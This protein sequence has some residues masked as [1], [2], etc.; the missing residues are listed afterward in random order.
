MRHNFRELEIWKESKKM[1]KAVYL[2]SA[3]LPEN[4]RFGLKS[5]MQRS[6]VSVPSNIAEGSGRSTNK[7]FNRFVDIALGSSY[8]L[9]TQLTIA[10]EIF[11]LE[12]K[13][14]INH[15]NSI[16]RRIG[17]FKNTLKS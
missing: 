1:A 14:L 17:A 3:E 16:Q 11:N 15:L 9:E 7:D 5:Q 13:E 4:E 12:T 10:G 6:A 8:E 2:F